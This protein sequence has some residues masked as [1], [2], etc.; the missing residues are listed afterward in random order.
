M[1]TASISE[2]S[3]KDYRLLQSNQEEE[4]WIKTFNLPKDMYWPV[5]A[6]ITSKQKGD[7][8]EEM[9]K[10]ANVHLHDRQD[11]FHDATLD[12]KIVKNNNL[13]GNRIENKYVC[14]T[15]PDSFKT[16][17]KRGYSLESG[18]RAKLITEFKEGNYK[19]ANG[20]NFQQVHPEN[21]HYGLFT[22]V[23]GN[24]AAHYWVPYHL[25]SKQAGKGNNEIGK[26]P[27]GSQHHGA[28][29]EGQIG[30]NKR[31]CD[32]FLLDVTINTLFITDF[33]KYDLSKY[34]NLIY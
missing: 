15:K 30:R 5:W 31:F 12:E 33:D 6:P 2:L 16:I 10:N 23:F 8:W 3:T 13:K 14:I 1:I 32:L 20:G 4:R 28:T 11:K 21:A 9:Y 34:E 18:D 22:A 25:I 29:I 24:G 26:I 27:L 19:F 17:N 7:Q